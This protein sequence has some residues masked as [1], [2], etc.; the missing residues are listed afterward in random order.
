MAANQRAPPISNAVASTGGTTSAVKVGESRPVFSRKSMRLQRWESEMPSTN[1][2][3]DVGTIQCPHCGLSIWRGKTPG[4]VDGAI[5][6]NC[7]RVLACEGGRFRVMTNAEFG[8]LAAANPF[9][10][11][12]YNQARHRKMHMSR[13]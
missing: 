11:V 8:R 7:L 5:C 6:H 3:I 10:L 1:A 9:I 12:V 4:P 13:N 2:T